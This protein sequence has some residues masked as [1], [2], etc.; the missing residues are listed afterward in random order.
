MYF[1]PVVSTLPLSLL[2]KVFNKNYHWGSK[3][4]IDTTMNTS[5]TS[6][7]LNMHHLAVNKELL[8]R[9]CPIDSFRTF[10]FLRVLS[11]HVCLTVVASFIH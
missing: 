3:L 6:M 9:Y 7:Y 5:D 10:F 1:Y 2:E 4:S 11:Y 8:K